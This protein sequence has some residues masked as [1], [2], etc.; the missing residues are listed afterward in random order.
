MSSVPDASD[1]ARSR[2][3]CR[4]RIRASRSARRDHGR[5]RTPGGSAFC[6]FRCGRSS[7]SGGFRGEVTC[8]STRLF[9]GFGTTSDIYFYRKRPGGCP[10]APA[11]GRQKGFSTMRPSDRSVRGWATQGGV[12]PC[13][14]GIFAGSP[15][16]DASF[17]RASFK[18]PRSPRQETKVSRPNDLGLLKFGW[19]RAPGR[20]A[21]SRGLTL[22]PWRLARGESLPP[23]FI[24]LARVNASI[25]RRHNEL[26]FCETAA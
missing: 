20:R 5:G 9:C 1:P 10:I 21:I 7:L 18:R 6:R 12:L 16:T 8:Q 15:G 22:R 3:S 13:R 23:A 14:G 19:E 25:S 11:K 24:V 4:A 26:P 2:M 17:V